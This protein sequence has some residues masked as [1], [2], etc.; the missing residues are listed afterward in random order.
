MTAMPFRRATANRTSATLRA[1]FSSSSGSAVCDSV[2]D[3]VVCVTSR[4]YAC[5]GRLASCNIW[6]R[7]SHSAESPYFA[8]VVLNRLEPEN[9]VSYF[10]EGMKF[11]V[12]ETF[13]TY[14][15][16]GTCARCDVLDS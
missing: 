14:R 11:E 7:R 9:L 13:L 2:A 8:L 6:P 1:R 15:D 16:D 3:V 5:D 4:L 12:K 10:G